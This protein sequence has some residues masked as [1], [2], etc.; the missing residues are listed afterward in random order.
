MS[1]NHTC[2]GACAPNKRLRSAP[3][4][5]RL[6][7]PGVIDGGRDERGSRTPGARKPP[8]PGC[9]GSIERTSA[10]TPPAVGPI[11][12]SLSS[13]LACAILLSAGSRADPAIALQENRHCVLG[14]RRVRLHARVSSSAA[15]RMRLAW[16]L[17]AGDRVLL[18]R[19]QEAT[20]SGADSATVAIELPVPPVGEGVVMPLE[21]TV[22]A[23]P[24]AA[25]QGA[26]RLSRRLWV[27]P[28]DPFGGRQQWLRE[29]RIRVL[30]PEGVTERVLAEAGVPFESVQ[31]AA[32]LEEESRPVTL[33]TGTGISFVDYPALGGQLARL[34]ARGHKVLCLS[35][36]DGQLPLPGAANADLPPPAALDFRRN[37][38]IRELDKRLD[39]TPWASADRLA[40]VGVRVAALGAR[41]V[42][43]VTPAGSGWPWAAVKF[44]A[45]GRFVFCGFP[46]IE[47]WQSGPTPRFLLLRI[48]EVMHES[49][50]EEMAR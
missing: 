17:R 49:R 34:A 46:I 22:S 23:A 8:R 45:G 48:L 24:V 50:G 33:V 25:G 4:T 14:G 13:A 38:I 36:R 15:G 19:E 32:V 9:C 6:P 18:R 30:D 27:F 3:A 20:V 2:P 41:I 1:K 16:M 5:G 29:L 31:R 43:E 44:E 37:D 28:A 10:I 12:R 40:D 21:L 35:P 11:P 47:C 26:V 42:W 7:F 39:A